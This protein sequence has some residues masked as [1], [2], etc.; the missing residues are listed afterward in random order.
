MTLTYEAASRLI[1]EALGD[2]P[3]NVAKITKAMP[4]AAPNSAYVAT[5]CKMNPERASMV[6]GVMAK[7]QAL[8]MIEAGETVFE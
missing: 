8:K 3:R 2:L 7:L 5:W 1:E 4:D 6:V